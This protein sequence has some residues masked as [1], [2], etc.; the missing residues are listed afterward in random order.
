[1]LR[2]C[3]EPGCL[4]KCYRDNTRCLAHREQ[5]ANR[6]ATGNGGRHSHLL[7]MEP[8]AWSERI[9]SLAE[10]AEQGLALF[11]TRRASR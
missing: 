3:Q 11:P 4:R 10:R 2:Y 9:Q 8:A 7:P 1:M 5:Q 6:R